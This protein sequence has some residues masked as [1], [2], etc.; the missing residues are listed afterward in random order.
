M[1]DFDWRNI[2]RVVFDRLGGRRFV[3][4]LLTPIVPIIAGWIAMGFGFSEAQ[5]ME[6]TIQTFDGMVYLVTT[7]I[8][9]VSL[10]KAARDFKAN[11]DKKNETSK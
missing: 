11:G 4:A 5:A 3:S 9:G 8:G 10:Q 2:I 7:F 6:Y 1:M